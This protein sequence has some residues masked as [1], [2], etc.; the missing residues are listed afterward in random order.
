MRVVT[1]KA[2]ED[3]LELLDRYAIKYGLNRSEAIRKAIE[4]LVKDEV[5]KETVPV[6]RVEKIRL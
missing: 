2:E 6:A 1:F 5:N 4:N 3:L